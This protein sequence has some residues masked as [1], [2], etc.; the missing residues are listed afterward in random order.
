M[1]NW[2]E[3]INY[4]FGQCL[5]ARKKKQMRMWMELRDVWLNLSLLA[6]CSWYCLQKYYIKW[7]G[8][9]ERDLRCIQWLENSNSSGTKFIF[10]HHYLL[11]SV[12][13]DS[14][15]NCCCCWLRNFLSSNVFLFCVCILDSSH[16]QCIGEI[17]NFSFLITCQR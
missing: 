12:R 11:R 5:D 8:M 2:I 4:T 15:A 16:C 17:E 14:W 1:A 13:I 6:D 10:K 7:N 9:S 3:M